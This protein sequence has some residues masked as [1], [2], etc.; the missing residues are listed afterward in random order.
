MAQGQMITSEDYVAA[1]LQVGKKMLGLYS[2][3]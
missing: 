1:V 2:K 3:T